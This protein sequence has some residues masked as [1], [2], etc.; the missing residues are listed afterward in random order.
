[1]GEDDYD[2]I[3][4][5]V[6]EGEGGTDLDPDAAD[7]YEENEGAGEEER[8]E[9]TVEEERRPRKA[10]R[11][12]V[13][14]AKTA[15]PVWVWA[16]AGGGALVAIAAILAFLH[17]REANG[18][19]MTRRPAMSS[20]QASPVAQGETEPVSP[21]T[22]GTA[23]TAPASPAGTPFPSSAQSVPGVAMG[24]PPPV[25]PAGAPLAETGGGGMPSSGSGN[26]VPSVVA[27]ETA[28]VASGTA[29]PGQGIL[30]PS[31]GDGSPMN[32][33]AA[34]GT[35]PGVT[36]SGVTALAATLRANLTAQQKTLKSILTQLKALRASL[37]HPVTRAAAPAGLILRLREQ[38]DTAWRR[39]RALSDDRD[40]LRLEVARLK[41]RLRLVGAG[42]RIFQGWRLIGVSNSAAILRNGQGALRV[43]TPGHAFG[44]V[45]ILA[46]DAA[47]LSV[48]TSAGRIPLPAI[49]LP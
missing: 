14:P 49:R 3:E 26:G 24:A 44:G 42:R 22:Y 13:A 39:I 36:S 28:P 15:T 43:V 40:T 10:R 9:G 45:K 48:R 2:V 11:T 37:R 20:A 34:A 33:S 38:R 4:E 31:R 41:E 30:A 19:V 5:T 6:V 16:L 25:V 8:G 17:A 35:A 32:A 27:P 29:F 7:G 12:P 18:Q 1:M 23:G 46:I 47:N 21:V